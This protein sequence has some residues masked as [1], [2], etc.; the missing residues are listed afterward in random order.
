MA[1]FIDVEHALD[2][3][4][5]ENI[6]VDVDNIIISQP[7]S[8]EEALE[9]CEMYAREGI[10]VV[11]VD[12]VAAL[13]PRAEITGEMGD[14]HIGIQARLMGQAMRK[15]KSITKKSGT[16]IF[17]TNQVRM[18]IGVMFGDPTMTP[19]G[20]A[21]KFFASIRVRVTGLTPKD[22]DKDKDKEVVSKTVKFKIVKNKL[23]PPFKI[24]EAKV[25]FTKGFDLPKN[26]FSGLVATGVIEKEGNTY[27]LEGNKLAVGKNKAEVALSELTEEEINGLY[28]DMVMS[29]NE[30]YLD[31]LDR[32]KQL[33]TSIEKKKAKEKDTTEKES[34]LNEV[35]VEILRMR[36]KC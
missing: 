26:I 10:D 15:L 8:G 31:L 6:G 36:L 32:K 14:S 1:A 33:L 30:D 35:G 25:G 16:T 24:C 19:G 27:Y 22:E 7:E 11:A 3:A 5:A 2:P 12:S 18:K 4:W 9:L 13:T 21:L 20:K 17:F 29:F 34:E 23:A 28:T